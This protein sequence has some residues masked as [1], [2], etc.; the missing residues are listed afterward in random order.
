MNS[1]AGVTLS[2]NLSLFTLSV[3]AMKYW[4]FNQSCPFKLGG[5][6]RFT[7]S[8]LPSDH[9]FTTAASQFSRNRTG[10]FVFLSKKVHK[11][12]DTL[13]VQSSV[14]SQINLF[15]A[16]NYQLSPSW[17]I[18]L[19]ADVVGYTFGSTVASTLTFGEQSNSSEQF[20]ATPSALNVLLGGTNNVGSLYAELML[21]KKISRSFALHVGLTSCIHEYTIDHP[22]LYTNS[23]GTVIEADRFRSNSLTFALGFDY[24]IHTKKITP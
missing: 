3:D 13:N 22:V 21:C 8:Y 4:S 18:E 17:N 11:N 16:F 9:R 24:L 6:L 1:K 23:A 20:N 10:P 14:L 2:S 12:I 19:N 15:L 7:S 5:G